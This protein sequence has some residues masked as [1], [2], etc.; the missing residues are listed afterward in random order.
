MDDNSNRPLTPVE[1]KRMFAALD[2]AKANAVWRDANDASLEELETVES[3]WDRLNTE[4]G[5]L[6]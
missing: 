6:P 3:L 4:E 2:E 1:A 5:R